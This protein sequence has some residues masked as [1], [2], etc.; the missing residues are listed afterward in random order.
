TVACFADPC[1]LS[2]PLQSNPD[3]KHVTVLGGGFVGCE[4]ALALA[5][6]GRST[7]TVV[8]QA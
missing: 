8:H 6:R 1:A 7:G 3:V 2:W 5:E 4:V